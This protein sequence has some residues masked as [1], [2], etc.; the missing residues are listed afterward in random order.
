MAEEFR[1]RQTDDDLEASF[2][3]CPRFDTPHQLT[4]AQIEIIIDRALEKWKDDMYQGV[5]HRVVNW[6]F[7]VI[8]AAAVG[9]AVVAM[10]KGWLK[11]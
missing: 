9:L 3:Q 11:P 7:Y 2:K 5:G 8:G 6:V 10:Q 1:R 4:D